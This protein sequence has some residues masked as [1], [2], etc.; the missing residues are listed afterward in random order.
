MNKVQRVTHGLLDWYRGAKRAL[1]WRATRDPYA[2]LVSEVMLQQT[3]VERVLPAYRRWMERWPTL[4]S[5]AAA[6]QAE[7]VRAWQGLG[8]NRRAI[9]LYR[10]ARQVVLEHGGALPLSEEGLRRLPGVGPY[11]AAAVLVFSQRA[12]LLA[13]DTN[14]RRVLWRIFFGRED[15]QST[16]DAQLRALW[17]AVLPEENDS[18]HQALMDFGSAICLARVPACQI[19]PLYA[20]CMAGPSLLERPLKPIAR[21]YEPFRESNRFVRGRVL[22]LLRAGPMG[23]PALLEGLFH[24]YDITNERSRWALGELCREG[25]LDNGDASYKLADGRKRGI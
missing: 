21:L 15:E 25:F 9:A 24:R 18:F 14:V 22:E 1:P 19:C 4:P 16:D 20:D 12:R 2:V 17:L 6:D 5:L 8:Y 11:T 10:L 13:L 7:I 23:E 3:Q